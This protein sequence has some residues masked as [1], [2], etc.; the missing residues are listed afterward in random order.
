MPSLGVTGFVVLE[1]TFLKVVYIYI[2]HFFSIKWVSPL[3][4]QIK[5]FFNPGRL[6]LILDEIGLVFWRRRWNCKIFTERRRTTSDQKIHSGELK[7]KGNFPLHYCDVPV[8]V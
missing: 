7:Q 2:S 8:L 5:I 4:E 6:A 1:K 3:F